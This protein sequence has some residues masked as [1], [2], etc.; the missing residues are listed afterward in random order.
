VIVHHRVIPARRGGGNARP[1]LACRR[2][3][4]MGGGRQGG[5]TRVGAIVRIVAYLATLAV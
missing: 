1:G 4:Y 2:L 3:I 5:S